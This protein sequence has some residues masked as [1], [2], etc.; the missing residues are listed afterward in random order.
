MLTPVFTYVNTGVN[1]SR[2]LESLLILPAGL[3][4]AAR[5][6]RLALDEVEERADGDARGALRAEGLGLVAPCRAG[7]V[8]VRPGDA[9]GE[10]L[11]EGSGGDGAGLAPADV[12]DVGDVGLDLLGVLL[13]ERQLPE[14]LADLPARLDDFVDQLLI[15]AEDARVHVAEG[16]RDRARQRR[17]VDDA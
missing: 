7:D 15:R 13:V 6:R 8:E 4:R 5:T 12:L 10:L 3:F 2:I 1:W 16:D 11:D 9:V 14:L 17:H